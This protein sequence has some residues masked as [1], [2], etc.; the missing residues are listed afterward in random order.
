MI[1]ANLY[2]SLADVFTSLSEKQTFPLPERYG[3]SS[4]DHRYEQGRQA[5]SAISHAW[6][7]AFEIAALQGKLDVFEKQLEES[8][9]FCPWPL[10]LLERV[11]LNKFFRRSYDYEWEQYFNTFFRLAR[12]HSSKGLVLKFSSESSLLDEE[13]KLE[14]NSD[15]QREMGCAISHSLIYEVFV[16]KRLD[17]D[18][19]NLHAKV[20]SIF[21]KEYLKDLV[22]RDAKHFGNV[23]T[24]TIEDLIDLDKERTEIIRTNLLPIAGT[25]KSNQ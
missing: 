20:T 9:Y 3:S 4:S 21:I 8:T 6:A 16:Q 12:L 25:I 15:R 10:A 14:E 24:S 18:S 19:L 17:G 22:K 23:V 13:D 11:E 1:K 5:T 7:S 2:S